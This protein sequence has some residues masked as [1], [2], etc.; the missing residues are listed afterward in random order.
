M[1]RLNIN[2]NIITIFSLHETDTR[3]LSFKKLKIII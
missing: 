3:D 1:K 2:N